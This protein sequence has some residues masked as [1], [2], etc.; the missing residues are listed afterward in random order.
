MTSL[1]RS[2]TMFPGDGWNKTVSLHPPSAPIQCQR[3]FNPCIHRCQKCI[4]GY[5]KCCSNKPTKDLSGEIR[6]PCKPT[7]LYK[8]T[9]R[10]LSGGCH[11]A[12]FVRQAHNWLNCFDSWH[13]FQR[14]PGPAAGHIVWGPPELDKAASKP[15]CQMEHTHTRTQR[16]QA[17]CLRNQTRG[18]RI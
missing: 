6:H 14:K 11:G 17:K 16:W 10:S 3:G 5:A 18:C 8:V 9:P 13:R 12:A 2:F 1:E 7:C 15:K 4:A